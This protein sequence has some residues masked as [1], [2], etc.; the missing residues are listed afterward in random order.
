MLKA[1][2]FLQF[3]FLQKDELFCLLQTNERKTVKIF[4]V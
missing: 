1:S 2:I 4:Y 3:A